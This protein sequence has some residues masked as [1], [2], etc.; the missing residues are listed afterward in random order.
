MVGG[1]LD[2]HGRNYNSFK[3][4]WRSRTHRPSVTDLDAL[5]QEVESA[6]ANHPPR[7]RPGLATAWVLI[8]E[9]MDDQGEKWLTHYRLRR[10]DDVVDARRNVVGRAQR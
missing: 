5:R 1:R 7:Q 4:L 3:H 8:S 6:L 10:R 9:F 2:L